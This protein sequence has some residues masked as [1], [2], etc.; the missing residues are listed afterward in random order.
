M[1]RFLS[2]TLSV[3][4][5]ISAVFGTNAVVFAD[6]RIECGD[7]GGNVVA[8][9]N[10]ANHTLT[11]TGSGAM[12]DYLGSPWAVGSGY[13][14]TDIII[15]NGITHIG[16]S[17]FAGMLRL[18]NVSIP[19]TVKSI[20]KNAFSGSILLKSVHL[21]ASVETI[22][23]GAFTTKGIVFKG[24]FVDKNNK[25]FTDVNG[26]L[27]DK[28]KE[29]LYL[30]PSAGSTVRLEIPD[31]V[32]TIVDKAAVNCVNLKE[33]VIPKSVT[34]LGDEVFTGEKSA[35]E[36]ITILNSELSL[37]EQLMLVTDTEKLTIA[38]YDNSTA[39]KYAKAHN[40]SFE[41]IDKQCSHKFDSGKVT[42][43]P[44]CTSIGVKIYTCTVCGKNRAEEMP[45]ISHTPIKDDAVAADCTKTGLTEGSHCS[46]CGKILQKQEVV[47]K[48]NHIYD[49][50]KVTTAA[51]CNEIGIK[52][53]SCSICGDTYDEEIP[54]TA[55]KYDNGKVTKKANC[56]ATGIKTYTCSLCGETKT[57]T[58]AKTGHTYKNV[59]TKATLSKNGKIDN[60]C[61]VCGKISKTTTIN[62]AKTIKLNRNV[63][64]TNGTVQRPSITVTDSKGKALTYKKDFVVEYSNF[65]SKNVG[66]YTVTVKLIGNYSGTKTF[67]YYINPKPTEFVP[68]NK[69]GFKA[70][71]KGFTIKWN[72][73]ASQTT[74]Y[75]IQYATKRD[76]SNA[77]TITIANPNTTSYTSKG[78]AGN[79]RYYVR[80][81][82]YKKIGT[83]TFYSNWNSGVK[84]VVTLR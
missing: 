41:V 3:L 10:A 7:K 13:D 55:H 84:S 2:L 11:L 81:R 80:V 33:V 71:S 18:E 82:T 39:Q 48:T 76:F 29:T 43:V 50:G 23:I 44:T 9:Y 78:R 31:T 56:K 68:S 51:T 45:M 70:I 34:A 49:N 54:K 73:Q 26:M 46:V 25:S 38:G 69:G 47:P 5:I 35:V 74:G 83:G 37:P 28:N 79:T 12:Q 64:T 20:G 58:I 72:K 75:Q 67:P 65:N 59:V 42:T 77:A 30:I 53:Y 22:G 66:R 15:E 40:I 57:E 17:A 60:K 61:S 21:P 4:M 36:K 6:D 8:N 63:I 32:K 52:T 62:Y 16:S 24:V 14:I 19:S 1:K 27:L